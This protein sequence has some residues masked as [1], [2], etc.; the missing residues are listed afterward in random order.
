[1]ET[2]R[3]RHRIE[4]G[5]TGDRA[6]RSRNPPREWGGGIAAQSAAHLSTIYPRPI[7]SGTTCHRAATTEDFAL[8]I[9]LIG[10]SVG[11]LKQ[12]KSTCYSP[13]FIEYTAHCNHKTRAAWEFVFLMIMVGARH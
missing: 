6:P 11:V 2:Q 1:M 10:R 8:I 9:A 13:N 7:F 3:E 5:D 12:V 4:G